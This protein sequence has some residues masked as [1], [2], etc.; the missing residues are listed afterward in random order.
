M[1]AIKA[2]TLLAGVQAIRLYH[3]SQAR[4]WRREHAILPFGKFKIPRAAEVIFSSR[5][6]DCRPV[7]VTIH[8]ELDFALTPPAIVADAPCQVGTDVMALPRHAVQSGYGLVCTAADCCASIGR[9]SRLYRQARTLT[10]K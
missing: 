8:E 10:H 2:E 3:L 6:A 1:P 5:T 4:V 7:L 9:E